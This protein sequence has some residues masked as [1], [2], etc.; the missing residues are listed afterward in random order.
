MV[1]KHL[2]SV[3]EYN[4]WAF[5]KVLLR[6]VR[7]RL[8]I[9]EAS[10]VVILFAV[11]SDV[12]GM[13]VWHNNTSI[14]VLFARGHLLSSLFS[15]SVDAKFVALIDHT[16][17]VDIHVREL[18]LVKCFFHIFNL[19]TLFWI[20]IELFLIKLWR[21]LVNNQL[22][23]NQSKATRYACIK[24][25]VFKGFDWNWLSINKLKV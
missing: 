22:K 11:S 23:L 20:L 19:Y 8:S 4:I 1:W 9:S 5:H 18:S 24:K 12:V 6:E 21:C 10:S 15:T 3:L 25:G 2:Y 16:S 13:P 14:A 17:E 7:E